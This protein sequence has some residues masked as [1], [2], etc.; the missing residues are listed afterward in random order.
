MESDHST[1]KGCQVWLFSAM[2]VLRSLFGYAEGAVS[3]MPTIA[4]KRTQLLPKLGSMTCFV[5][6]SRYI[7]LKQQIL[8]IQ[9]RSSI[10]SS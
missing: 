1:I 8:P 6:A 2:T 3:V 9:Q 5:G 7:Y 10:G 4:I